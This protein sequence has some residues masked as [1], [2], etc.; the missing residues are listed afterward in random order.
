MLKKISKKMK[1]VLYFALL[2]MIL[3]AGS[4]KAQVRIGG[5]E[6]PHTTAVLDLNASDATNDGNRGLALPRVSLTPETDQLNGATPKDGTL[7]YNTNA[8]FGVGL[9]YWLTDKWVKLQLEGEFKEKDSIVGNEVTGV[10][11]S[12]GLTRAGLGT[13]DEPYTLGIEDGGVTSA[14]IANN[15]VTSE[16][17]SANSVDHRHLADGSVD[18]RN[19]RDGS[20]TIDH[21]SSMGADDGGGL[22]Y[23]QYYGWTTVL[24]PSAIRVGQISLGSDCDGD[25]V[26]QV[27]I[28]IRYSQWYIGGI[29]VQS[30]SGL[31]IGISYASTRYMPVT[32]AQCHSWNSQASWGCILS[33]GW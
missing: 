3:G 28:P 22:I 32:S 21:L 30:G 29:C 1:K 17:L 13:N 9:Y 11:P 10:T 14:R 33:P 7:V 27:D 16:K 6:A 12:G 15:A 19:I 20:I 18:T 2:P 8:D 4:I 5:N 24:I 26:A 25:V 23:D 31:A